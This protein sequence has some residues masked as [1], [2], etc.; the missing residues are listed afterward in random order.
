MKQVIVALLFL[1]ISN[2]SFSQETSYVVN[3]ATANLRS[4]P[5]TKSKII[6]VLKKGDIVG[7]TTLEDTP[8]WVFVTYYGYEGYVN[9]KLLMPLEENDKYKNWR[10][11]DVR[12]GD[13]YN[14]E[15]IR[16]E[17]DET[18][19]NKLI[20][21]TGYNSDVVVKLMNMNDVCI[22]ISYIRAGD[23]YTMSNIPLGNYYLKT[24]Y[25]K[26]Y[27]QS[28]ENDQ[29]KVRFLRNPI[30][31]KGEQIL[32]F[33]KEYEGTTR[34]GSRSYESYQYSYYELR[35]DVDL[36][37]SLQDDNKKFNTKKITEKDFNN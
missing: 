4:G 26:D 5:S 3:G 2:F 10:S 28:I 11:V 9:I 1:F 8:D 27:R 15:N 36:R 16:P 18:A 6:G 19:K 31:K 35:L 32:S 25:G 34:Q 37:S 33:T 12:T 23:T 21:K 29:C 22:R 24:A 7:V 20:I 17:F 30:Y 13:D 14:C